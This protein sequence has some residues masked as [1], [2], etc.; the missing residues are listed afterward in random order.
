MPKKGDD[1]RA[2]SVAAAKNHMFV[3]AAIVTGIADPV[4]G[5]FEREY[6]T[7]DVGSGV[8]S[9]SPAFTCAVA[10]VPG[11]RRSTPIRVDDT[12]YTVVNPRPNGTGLT[13]LILQV[14]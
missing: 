9:Y 14:A 3:D 10:D 5:L 8:E 2:A 6:Y 7:I 4:M 13:T 11:V 12:D 1:L